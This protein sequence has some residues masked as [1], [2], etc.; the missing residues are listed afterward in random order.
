M[1]NLTLTIDGLT[2]T[3]NRFISYERVLADTGQTE[4]SI[5]GTPLDTG[6]VYEPKHVWTVSAMVT[7]EQW[8]AL[9]AIFRKSDNL[10]R[11]Q[12]NYRILLEDSV[13]NFV[14]VGERTRAIAR[15]GNKVNFAGGT[16][17][18]A[19]FYT[20]MF[21]P[22]SQWQRNQLYPYIAS[23]TLRE[24]D[25]VSDSSS[26]PGSGGG[27]TPP[28]IADKWISVVSNLGM[29]SN[30]GY[31]VIGNGNID[32]TLPT[33]AVVGDAVAIM[34]E[35]SAVWRVLSNS[36]SIRVGDQI[37]TADGFLLSTGSGCSIY[38][39]CSSPNNWLAISTQGIFNVT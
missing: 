24:L 7:Y 4:Y 36:G 17:Y 30:T 15:F 20:R 6:S 22:K 5:V 2:A 29:R 35:S 14:E 34:G 28:T 13:E 23:F 31:V 25:I 39:V 12:G 16:A 27:V 10:R 33:S 19:A 37:T 38:L 32:L 21:E 26:L 9:A 8:F 11:Q 18:P 3:L 1:R